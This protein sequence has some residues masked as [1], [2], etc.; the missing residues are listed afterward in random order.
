M[1]V[2]DKKIMWVVE[3][4]VMVMDDDEVLLVLMMD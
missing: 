1:V 4:W 3:H 2:V